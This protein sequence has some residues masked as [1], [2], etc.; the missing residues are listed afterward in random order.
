MFHDITTG[1]NSVPGQPGFNAT[2]GYDQATGLGSIDASV[3]VNHWSDA[4]GVPGFTV[5]A[6]AK[7]LAVS[8]AS[9]SSII[10]KIAVS[11]GFNGAVAFSVSGLPAGVTASFTPA[12][13]PAPGSGSIVLK[14]RATGSAKPGV[15]SATVTATSGST[16]HTAPLSVSVVR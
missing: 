6:S 5:M 3:L 12:R 7:S 15:Y 13:L 1:K 8:S 11:G 4:V 9:N 10:L 2:T 16:K 14:L